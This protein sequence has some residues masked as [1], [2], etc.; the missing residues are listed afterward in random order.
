MHHH[1][2]ARIMM[3]PFIDEKN[4]LFAP[5]RTIAH[6]LMHTI[7]HILM[8]AIMHIAM[9]RSLMMHDDVPGMMYDVARWHMPST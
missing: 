3:H 1:H 5:L 7:M 2:D 9:H 8:H 6:I 4:E